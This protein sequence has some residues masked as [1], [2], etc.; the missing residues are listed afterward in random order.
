LEGDGSIDLPVIGKS[1]LNRVLNPRIVFTSHIH[2]IGMYSYIQKELG[3][4]GRFQKSGDNVLRYIIGDR[5][6]IIKII[7]IIHS[8]LYTPKNTRL[9][10]LV[11]F[12][13]LKYNLNI[14]ESILNTSSILNNS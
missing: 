8:K 7:S 4:I 5:E 14:E 6:G 11:H 1:K 13:N 10:Q 3:G 2:N 9:N 12:I